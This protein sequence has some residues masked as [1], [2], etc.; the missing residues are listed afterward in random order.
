MCRNIRT[1]HN[2]E[3]P[4]SEEEIRASALQY[5]RKLS[6]V[7]KPSRANEAVFERAVD[8][9]AAATRRLLGGLVTV[10]AARDREVEGAKARKRSAARFA[11]TS[12]G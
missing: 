11:R 5:V 8:E 12:T 10:S 6:G 4:A 2:F 3:P 7:T 1:L 9:V